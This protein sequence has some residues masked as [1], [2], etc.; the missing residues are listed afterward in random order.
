MSAGP[1]AAQQQYIDAVQS[2]LSL[3]LASSTCPVQPSTPSFAHRISRSLSNLSV[4]ENEEI[5]QSTEETEDRRWS[6]DSPSVCRR[7]GKMRSETL[8]DWLTP[9]K[10]KRKVKEIKLPLDPEQ[11]TPFE[12]SQYL[13]HKLQTGGPGGTGRVLPAPLISD[14]EVWVLRQ[15]VSGKIFLDG[16]SDGWGSSTSRAP[17]FISLLKSVS[18]QLRRTF[19]ATAYSTRLSS[20]SPTLMEKEEFSDDDGP[21]GVRRMI[22]AYDARSSALASSPSD[23]G[24]DD[25]H[26]APKLVAQ[27]TG[28]SVIERWRKWEA[29]GSLVMPSQHEDYVQGYGRKRN[30]S[31]ASDLSRTSGTSSLSSVSETTSP[32]MEELLAEREIHMAESSADGNIKPASPVKELLSDFAL[33]DTTAGLTPPPSYTSS[34]GQSLLFS[35]ASENPSKPSNGDRKS[36]TP[37][38]ES[39]KSTGLHIFSDLIP[40]DAEE[41]TQTP[42]VSHFPESHSRHHDEPSDDTR[43]PTIGLSLRRPY[44]QPLEL[45]GD[46]DDEHEEIEGGHWETARRVTLRA[47]QPITQKLLKASTSGKLE[48]EVKG[49]EIEKQVERLVDRV[50]ELEQKVESVTSIHSTSSV[51]NNAIQAKTDVSFIDILGLGKNEGDHLPRKVRELPV[52]IFLVGVGVG[53]VLVRICLGR[54]RV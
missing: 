49:T 36:V 13:S 50:R 20:R 1:F 35:V 22:I 52:Y 34:L 10:E 30:F 47:T 46:A 45:V 32:V 19:N 11:W 51:S 42:S 27:H 37:T 43:Y 14:I 48:Q 44:R 28:E 21:I 38:P 3:G 8:P 26:E 12:L 16:S 15:R 6:M 5:D 40:A 31:D 33:S 24:C 7:T 17:P 25:Q 54:H 29:T 4:R 39:P 18:R 2:T 53:A 9:G 41:H 23:A